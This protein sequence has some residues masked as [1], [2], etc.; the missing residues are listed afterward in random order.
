MAEP[1][2]KLSKPKPDSFGGKEFWENLFEVGLI[3]KECPVCHRPAEVS[4]YKSRNWV[5]QAKCPE[6]GERSCLSSGF[7]AEMNIKEPAKF[8][9][10]ALTYASRMSRENWQMMAGLANDTVS[11]FLHIVE[12]CMDETV[13]QAMRDG[14]MLL[15]GEGVV[16][17]IDE[18]ILT[19][20]KYHKGRVSK[21]E[22]T[23]FGMV[24]V[25]APVKVVDDVEL[26]AAVR[27][28]NHLKAVELGRTTQ[29][30]RDLR[31]LVPDETPFAVSRARV[32]VVDGQGKSETVRLSGPVLP[33]DEEKAVDEC[34]QELTRRFVQARNGRP[35]KAIFFCVPD[36]THNT[37]IPLIQQYV[38]EGSMVF[39]DEFATYKCLRGL[40]YKHYTVCHKIEFSHFVIEGR[41]IIRVST[42]HIERVWV[43]LDKTVEHL[44]KEK[45]LR[46]L[47][48]E[49]YRQ[50]RLY[51]TKE[52]NLVRLLRDIAQV[53]RA[54]IARRQ[55]QE[56]AEVQADL[57]RR[58]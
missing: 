32:E 48:L 13:V 50:L 27:T 42:N 31:Q 20:N 57:L 29:S 28:A 46:S 30:R 49:S 22:T 25:D 6:H 8:V 9:H 51:G 14:E 19:V 3:Q 47:N 1:V 18:K 15:G 38:A 43:E 4:M 39:T 34:I 54:V 16:V 40:G 10:F 12:D 23:I 2:F 26:R 45:T 7:F 41:N 56:E 5:P 24:E 36:R 35:R 33:E 55:Q 37:L 52:S 17:E 53:W 58:F 21:K 44:T 11:K